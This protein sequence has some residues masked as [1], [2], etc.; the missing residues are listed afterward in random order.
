MY[1]APIE[2]MVCDSDYGDVGGYFYETYLEWT[3]RDNGK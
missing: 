1:K 2:K 3:N